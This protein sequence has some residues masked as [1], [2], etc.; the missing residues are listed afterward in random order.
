MSESKRRKRKRNGEGCVYERGDGLWAAVLSL[1]AGKRRMIYASTEDEAI[2]KLK[3][4]QIQ[5]LDHIPFC[6]ERLTLGRW[7]ETWL[8][9]V[10]PP[11]TAPKTWVVYEYFVRLHLAPKL[12][13][14][15]LVK[16]QPQDVRDFLSE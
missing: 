8:G 13:H 3:R 2:E 16:L 15:R 11:A 7:L 6:D 1:G 4:A 5:Q 10:K 12:G 14:I 9:N